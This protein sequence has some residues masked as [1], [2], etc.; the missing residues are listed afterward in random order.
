VQNAQS[1]VSFIGENRANVQGKKALGK[2]LAIPTA[3]PARSTA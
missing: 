2:S 3:N 1:S